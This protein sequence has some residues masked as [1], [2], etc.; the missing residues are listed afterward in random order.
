MEG[1]RTASTKE[2]SKP[3]ALPHSWSKGRLVSPSSTWKKQEWWFPKIPI[4]LTYLTCEEKRWILENDSKLLEMSPGNDSYAATGPDMEF[5]LEKIN[6]SLGTWY[7]SIYLSNAFS[8]SFSFFLN[9]LLA[10]TTEAACFQLAR[11]AVYLHCPTSEIYR[12]SR[13]IL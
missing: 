3:R 10:K 4:Q 11:T 6:T 7:A 1:T 13:P 5:L 2:N 8:F 9:N 12:P